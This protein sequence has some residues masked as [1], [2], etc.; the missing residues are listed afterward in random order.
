VRGTNM[1]MVRCMVF[2]K[3][4]KKDGTGILL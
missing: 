4:K 3:E 2:L 1:F